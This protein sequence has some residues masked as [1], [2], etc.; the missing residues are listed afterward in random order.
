MVSL[1]LLAVGFY[2]SLFF[3]FADSL[4]RGAAMM[5]HEEVSG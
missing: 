4:N 3:Y 2:F 5:D 1:S